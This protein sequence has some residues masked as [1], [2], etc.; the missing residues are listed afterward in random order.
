MNGVGLRNHTVIR[1]APGSRVDGVW[2]PGAQ[3]TFTI[4]A[5]EAGDFAL[6]VVV[7]GEG[8]SD[9]V[10]IGVTVAETP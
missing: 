5:E 4:R 7:T 3:S 1:E 2:T 9:A 8:M 10:M 6:Q